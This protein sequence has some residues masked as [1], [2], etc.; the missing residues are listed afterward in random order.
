MVKFSV[1]IRRIS[2]RLPSAHVADVRPVSWM[3]LGHCLFR[4][5]E[6]NGGRGQT[7][8]V[9]RRGCLVATTGS[10]E[11][12]TTKAL[13]SPAPELPNVDLRPTARWI[14]QSPRRLV[15]PSVAQQVTPG[16]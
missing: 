1:F 4:L 3:R 15:N 7:V 11:C 10:R 2:E 8:R 16:P 13:G 5:R 12:W 6:R 9:S 14:D